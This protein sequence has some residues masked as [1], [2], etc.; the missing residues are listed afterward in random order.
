MLLMSLQAALANH[1][2]KVA[3]D[4]R[5]DADIKFKS[6]SQAYE[7]LSDDEKRHLY[8]THGMSAF[9][10]SRG[11]MGGAPTMDDIF[12]Q[13]FGGPMGGMPSGFGGAGSGP[14]KPRKGQDEEQP[15]EVTLEE[16]YRGKSA[17][18]ASTKNILCSHCKG[19]GGKEGAKPKQCEACHGR[20][21]SI[22]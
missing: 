14:R 21:T 12:A 5:A 2:D 9:D 7:I 10:N 3:E 19:K 6:I 15:Y 11:G 4:D 1:P 13:M 17:K 22:P 8:D 16:L 20:G 18:F